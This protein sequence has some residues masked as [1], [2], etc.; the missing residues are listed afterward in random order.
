MEDAHTL[1]GREE[2]WGQ[3]K[4]AAEYGDCVTGPHFKSGFKLETGGVSLTA[5]GCPASWDKLDQSM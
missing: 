4:E 2:A 3:D 1:R 5:A